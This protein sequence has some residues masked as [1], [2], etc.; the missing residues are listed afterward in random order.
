M[1]EAE[2]NP[3]RQAACVSRCEAGASESEES[4]KECEALD[5][6]A[7]HTQTSDEDSE[8]WNGGV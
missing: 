6:Q 5:E 3:K 1:T 7:Q 2:R 4:G 8:Q